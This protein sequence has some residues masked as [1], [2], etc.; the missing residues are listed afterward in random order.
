MPSLARFAMDKFSSF[1]EFGNADWS[2]YMTK[3]IW[4]EKE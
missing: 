4:E 1:V 3:Q 2:S